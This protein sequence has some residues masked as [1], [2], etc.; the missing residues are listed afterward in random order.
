M[1]EGGGPV[2]LTP[3][4]GRAGFHVSRPSYGGDVTEAVKY[5]ARALELANASDGSVAPRPPVG[6]V[7]VSPSGDV[8]GEGRTLRK[9]GPHAEAAALIAAGERARGA[10]VY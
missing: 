3:R 2:L 4:R 6:C 5:M 10:T 9:P 1:G 7:I 8:A